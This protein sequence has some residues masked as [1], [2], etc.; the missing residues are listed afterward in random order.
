MTQ[1]IVITKAG[2]DATTDTNVDHQVFN[3]DYDTLKYYASGYVDLVVSGSDVET[4]VTHN[5]GYIP[6]FVA[7]VN[8]YAFAD[9]T[10]FSMVPASINDFTFYD[11]SQVYADSTKL[12][13]KCFTNSST[14]TLRF[15]YKIF[16][17]NTGL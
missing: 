5:L 2:Y 4:T 3:S 11:T 6:F 8:N 17:N 12:Y 10:Y 7:F 14:V 1:K 9:P 13:F 15:Y 16:R